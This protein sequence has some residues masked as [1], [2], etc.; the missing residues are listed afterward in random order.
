MIVLY[1]S[2]DSDPE[3][4][5]LHPELTPVP[6]NDP[7]QPERDEDAGEVQRHKLHDEHPEH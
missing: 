2:W 4:Q 1:L 7:H 5:Q 3:L 6:V